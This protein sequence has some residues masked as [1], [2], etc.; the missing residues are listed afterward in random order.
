MDKRFAALG[1]RYRFNERL[2]GFTA[3]G[4][5]PEDWSA[6]PGGRGNPA[7]WILGHVACARRMILRKVGETV[8]EAPWEPLFAQGSTP[9][10]DGYPDPAELTA[11]FDASG[12]RLEA[13]LAALTDEDAAAEIPNAMPDG[14]RTVDGFVHFMYFHECY[15]LGQMGLLRSQR[16][17]PGIA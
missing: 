13:R 15:H 12:S 10:A 8:E 17:K 9:A 6:R 2:L 11:D 7:V 3:D 5:T 14:S 1:G 16:G 4:L